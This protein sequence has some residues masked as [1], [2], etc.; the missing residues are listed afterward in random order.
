MR[1][2]QSIEREKR[3]GGGFIGKEETMQSAS[4][5]K[6][7]SVRDAPQEGRR[8]PPSLQV[9]NMSWLRNYWEQKKLEA[10]AILNARAE[11]KEK[12]RQD[13]KAP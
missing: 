6:R 5:A 8:S 7:R 10:E 3:T 12:K 11:R 4:W 1:S 9:I 2:A 13:N